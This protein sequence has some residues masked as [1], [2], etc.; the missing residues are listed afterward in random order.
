MAVSR[1][2]LI[3]PCRD[4]ARFLERTVASI[5]SQ[6]VLPSLLVLVD[7][8]STDA[9]PE[10]ADRLARTHAWIRVV[11]R[12]DRGRRS[13]GPGVIDAFYAGL[14]AVVP[15]D[16]EFLGKIDMDL[17]LPAAYFETVIGLMRS[18]PRIG[19]VSGKPYYYRGEAGRASLVPEPCGQDI[20]IGALKFYRTECFLEIGGFVRAVM[21]DG[22]DAHTSR[23][24]GW[25]NFA[26]DAPELRFVHLRPMGS[27]HQGILEGRRR[28]GRGQWFMGTGLIY[29]LASAV[30]RLA[31]RPAVLGSIYMLRGWLE[32]WYHCYPRYQAAGFREFLHRYH[33][34]VLR[35]GKRRAC[36]LVLAPRDQA[37]GAR[38][39][40]GTS[41]RFPG[42]SV[43]TAQGN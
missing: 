27:S 11:H 28:W 10:I 34:L 22:I 12:Q 35:H 16:Y 15:Q 17:E 14:E 26:T 33:R 2:C 20:C 3:A 37:S 5:A 40:A 4:E 25:K 43:S 38:A 32:G 41:G 13:V 9:T 19:A 23:M 31:A 39:P 21:W 24:K 8:G 6:T 30:M 42:A 29:M 18:D 36:E 1:Y 7:D